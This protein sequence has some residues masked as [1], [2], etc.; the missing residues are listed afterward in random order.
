[1][2]ILAAQVFEFRNFASADLSFS[3]RL[4][5]FVGP[6]GQ[7][8]TNLIEALYCVAALRPLRNVPRSE[9]IRA[10]QQNASVTVA[11]QRASTGL[12]HSL[13]LELRRGGRSLSRDGKRCEAGAF[14]GH[15]VAVA[16][17]PDDL[18]ITKGAPEA[19]RRFLDR[20]LLN[21]KP[22]YLGAALR[23]A[24][25]LKARN[26]LLSEGAADALLEA[27]DPPLAG[28]GAL[29]AVARAR[30]VAEIAPRI[31][32]RF[33]SIAR[34]AP[35]LAVR[36]RSTL[37]DGLVDDSEERT[38]RAFLELLGE[39]R[40]K[41]RARGTTSV[42]PHLDDLELFFEETPI[43]TRASQGQHRA[44]VLAI[45]L[46]EIEHLTETI[47]EPPILLLD[48][49]SSE[50]DKERTQQLFESLA[51]FD[52]Q[53]ILTTTDLAQVPQR[54]GDAAPLLYRV[55]AGTV[56]FFDGSRPA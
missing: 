35:T 32:A 2:R 22:A 47:G 27:Y 18:E 30:Y 33:M 25:A 17:T 24:R 21:A 43:R 31:A 49:I 40:A 29:V 51:P 36:Y 42:G 15:L 48:D 41:D 7:G 44:L 1:M 20:A 3:P 26:K 9:L 12:T 6:N 37:K 8:K 46:A 55:N 39:K 52:G 38:R 34:P 23:Y 28:A 45:K 13:R 56:S 11:V 4:T 54:G 19:R 5:A 10:G 14:L 53:V 16:F 50:L